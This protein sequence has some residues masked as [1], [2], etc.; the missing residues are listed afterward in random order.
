M[1]CLGGGDDN[2][3]GPGGTPTPTPTAEPPGGDGTNIIGLPGFCEIGD[4]AT[5]I[6][7]DTGTIRFA[8]PP[9]GFQ[10]LDDCTNGDN[11]DVT[12]DEYYFIFFN[13]TAAPY[14]FSVVTPDNLE[15]PSTKTNN[16]GSSSGSSSSG[17]LAQ[18]MAAMAAQPESQNYDQLY[19]KQLLETMSVEYPLGSGGGGNSSLFSGGGFKN[20]DAVGDEIE[21]RFPSHVDEVNV[22]SNTS[23]IV[24][25]IG[26]NARIVVDHDLEY[27]PSDT[28]FECVN[29]SANVLQRTLCLGAVQRL[30]NI[31]DNNIVPLMTSLAGDVPDIDGSGLF[32]VFITPR[33][34]SIGDTDGDPND[35]PSIG[36]HG[37]TMTTDALPYDPIINPCGNEM[38][39]INVH[40]PDPAS[41]FGPSVD[42]TQYA[43]ADLPAAVTFQLEKWISF[44]EKV[45]EGGG[46]PED[47]WV[48]NALG[49]LF[50]DLA[51]FY[52]ESLFLR[53]LV[54]YLDLPSYISITS[55]RRWH[56]NPS[57]GFQ[58]LFGSYL[59][60]SQMDT[61]DEPDGD[62]IDQDLGFITSMYGELTGIENIEAAV[63]FP[64]DEEIET[65]FEA[66]FKFLSV[67]AAVEGTPAEKT[68]T[69]FPYYLQQ[70]ST[71]FGSG[72]ADASGSTRAGADGGSLDIDVNPNAFFVNLNGANVVPT[73]SGGTDTYLF[74]NPDR[75]T[76]APGNDFIGYTEALALNFVRVGGMFEANTNFQIDFSS[77]NGAGY[78]VRVPDITFPQVHSES[79]HGT[80]DQKRE[81]IDSNTIDYDA[82]INEALAAT[83][84]RTKKLVIVGEF[85]E[86]Q[87]TP[88]QNIDTGD[89]TFEPVSDMDF[90]N[91]TIP[92][93]APGSV[94]PQDFAAWVELQP[95]S[96]DG[97]TTA[98]PMLAI[99]SEDDVPDLQVLTEAVQNGD[100]LPEFRYVVTREDPTGVTEEAVTIEDANDDGSGPC[101]AFD[102]MSPAPIVE[103]DDFFWGFTIYNVH[104]AMFILNPI[105]ADPAY[106]PGNDPAVYYEPRM[107]QVLDFICEGGTVDDPDNNADDFV[108]SDELRLPGLFQEQILTYMARMRNRNLG[109][110][111]TAYATAHP[112]R[113]LFTDEDA[114]AEDTLAVDDDSRDTPGT[115]IQATAKD[116]GN[117]MGGYSVKNIENSLL[118]ADVDT[119]NPLI[120]DDIPIPVGFSEAAMNTAGHTFQMQFLPPGGV[121]NGT[122]VMNP[123]KTYTLVVG[124]IA[125]PGR[126]ELYIRSYDD[127]AITRT[128]VLIAFPE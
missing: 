113:N 75:F 121:G 99:V 117:N 11:R 31:I 46:D 97:T 65:E 66:I 71:L 55:T 49:L 25:F 105:P 29:T 61:S 82:A 57:L 81:I 34:N 103:A 119:I 73:S 14:S 98:Q 2:T 127:A 28:D 39:L 8:L 17:S 108:G 62:G 10:D 1:G 54:S 126:Y 43:N 5:L 44:G 104:R 7:D 84:T 90:Y 72:I 12:D 109:G 115:A 33:M 27:D 76:Y 122:L 92:S 91:I 20:G 96:D 106:S 26:N 23:G 95:T 87:F 52:T 114:T 80:L 110:G 24:Q 22:C 45:I 78:V 86:P 85:D 21:L 70:N 88:I 64:F 40:A 15:P 68:G 4:T 120:R 102:D 79:V 41:I 30:S 42:L 89:I 77:A 59:A 56:D 47:P 3:G 123:G 74:E 36:I 6:P 107:A 67:A 53:R 18:A 37:F 93:T 101:T 111:T 50:V 124:S 51:G 94:V 116:I 112:L 118:Q 69:D 9:D 32:T 19:A 128:G 58:Y 63:D 48:S 13:S 100:D 125:E 83:D 16:S 38:T 35:L 60:H